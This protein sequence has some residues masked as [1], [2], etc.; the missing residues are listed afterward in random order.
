ME[1]IAQINQLKK[2]IENI[3]LNMYIIQSN[4]NVLELINPIP[5]DVYS[6]L[7]NP[8]LTDLVSKLNVHLETFNKLLSP[9]NRKLKSIIYN[10]KHS[11][12]KDEP[13]AGFKVDEKPITGQQLNNQSHEN[14]LNF[15]DISTK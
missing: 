11:T 4:L 14:K 1:S 2:D 9:I 5:G 3:S 6:L 12:N 7:S 8:E 10:Q 15:N 13:Y